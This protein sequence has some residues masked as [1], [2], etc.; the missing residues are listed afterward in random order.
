MHARTHRNISKDFQVNT[1]LHMYKVHSQEIYYAIVRFLI[2]LIFTKSGILRIHSVSASLMLADCCSS[3][4]RPRS[5]HPKPQY[6]SHPL[7]SGDD[8]DDDDDLSLSIPS[9]NILL[10]CC[11]PVGRLSR[12]TSSA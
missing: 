1:F 10:I 8:D 3:S 11:C 7:L 6:S 4:G 9:Y 12:L 5:P 2:F